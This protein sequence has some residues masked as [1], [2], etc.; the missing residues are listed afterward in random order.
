MLHFSLVTS[1]LLLSTF[2]SSVL[3]IAS[4]NGTTRTYFVAAVER[5][6][7]YMPTCVT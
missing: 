3:G 1:I 6:W 5:D 4:L 2:I 7:D